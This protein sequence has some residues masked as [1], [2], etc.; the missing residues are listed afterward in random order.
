MITDHDEAAELIAKRFHDESWGPGEAWPCETDGHLETAEECTDWH[1][2]LA[3][4][5]LAAVD[6]DELVASRERA[7]AIA[8][9]LEEAASQNLEG[10]P[11]PWMA[12][13]PRGET[14]RY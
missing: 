13:W 12:G 4:C 2:S 5:A 9:A 11:A 3:E 10:V 6:F 14:P 8:C 1:R 7:I